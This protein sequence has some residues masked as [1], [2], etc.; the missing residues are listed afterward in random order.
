M[1]GLLF[2]SLPRNVQLQD[3]L[4]AAARAE[5]ERQGRFPEHG[6]ALMAWM[7][8]LFGPEDASEVRLRHVCCLLSDIAWRAHPDFRAERGLDV[9]LHGNW[10]AITARERAMLGAALFACFGG[11]ADDPA[12][13]LLP[14]LAD[15]ASLQRARMWGLALRLGP[16]ADRRHRRG[17]RERASAP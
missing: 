16:A 15:P 4:I 5:G 10:V 3:P 13:A 9:A 11:A 7:N 17:A 14:Q 12:A 2:D 1:K 8:G 6:D